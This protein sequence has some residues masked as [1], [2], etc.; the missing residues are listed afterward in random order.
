M[1]GS[2]SVVGDLAFIF[3]VHGLLIKFLPLKNNQEKKKIATRYNKY[4]K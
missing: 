1:F 2:S 4:S 3:Y